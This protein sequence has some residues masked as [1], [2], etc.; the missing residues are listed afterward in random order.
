M[1]GK[2]NW[3][4]YEEFAERM[5]GS[6]WRGVQAPLLK[7]D[8]EAVSLQTI[9]FIRQ[10][11]PITEGDRGGRGAKIRLFRRLHLQT[12]AEIVGKLADCTAV[13]FLDA[14][15]LATTEGGRKQGVGP[16]QTVLLNNIGV[17]GSPV[18]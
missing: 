10:P 8:M 18:V 3:D 5:T 13:V 15:Q 2:V 11:N 16:K 14:Y 12:T 7:L 6:Y 4:P 17:I 1:P 9:D